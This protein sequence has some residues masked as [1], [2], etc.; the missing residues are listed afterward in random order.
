MLL[1]LLLLLLCAAQLAASSSR[2]MIVANHVQPGGPSV[3][4][5]AQLQALLD[6]HPNTVFDVSHSRW[7]VKNQSIWLRSNRSLVMDST[8][9]IE[10][11]GLL[12]LTNPK[13]EGGGAVL[14]VTGTNISVA[15]GRIQQEILSACAQ[16]KVQ[17][18]PGACNF[19]VD[20]YYSSGITFRDMVVEGSFM[21]AVRVVG[22]FWPA[23][24]RPGAPPT[25]SDWVTLPGLVR[26]PVL[27]T[28]VTLLH[29]RN[30]SF[31]Q[32]RGFWT[33]ITANVI[34]SRNTILGSFGYAIDLDSSSSA[35]LV[36]N[37]YMKG[38]LWEGIFTEYSAV[39]NTIVG[40]TVLA[41]VSYDQ[42]IH[43]VSDS[44]PLPLLYLTPFGW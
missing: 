33:V 30:E 35:N 8:T 41:N 3:A 26:Q 19:G 32:L 18:T 17:P 14:T 36:V 12:P 10:G 20:I 23:G 2:V 9:V 42:G 1:L 24:I 5:V 16:A 22:G 6:A 29:H 43:I 40:N 37:N 39:G 11:T 31:F 28:N 7:T 4:T 38:C 34:F 13:H 25:S 27:I 44:P 21:S 15:G